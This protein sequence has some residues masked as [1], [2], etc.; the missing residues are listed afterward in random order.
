MQDLRHR[1]IT[2]ALLV[3]AVF[4]FFYF[5]REKLSA[6]YAYRAGR[7]QA[8]GEEEAA[9]WDLV[10]ATALD[11]KE[12]GSDL[13]AGRAEIFLGRGEYARAEA[14]LLR[15][16]EKEGESVRLYGLLARVQ[17][18]RGEY[19]RAEEYYARAADLGENPALSLA[20]AKNLA[21]WGKLSEAEN[22]LAGAAEGAGEE[23]SRYYLGLVR[24]NAGKFSAADFAAL[25][26]ESYVGSIALL[27]ECFSRP[28][29]QGAT[30]SALVVRADL[31]RRLGA[32]DL[33][34]GNLDAVLARNGKYRDAYLVLGKI[35]LALEDPVAASAAFEKALGLDGD[36]REALAYLQ[37]LYREAGNAERA[38]QL[39]ARAQALDG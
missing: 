26:G 6:H 4:G 7:M 9:L 21:R 20:R 24:A 15:A 17:H 3:L 22:L 1:K 5:C 25:R 27:E 32:E 18:V 11:E 38:E 33:A 37:R 16:L 39:G 28:E 12:E 13:A 23:E 29:A 31:F 36:N 35:F 14:E 8:A 34:L 19:A 10:L 30:D 2:I